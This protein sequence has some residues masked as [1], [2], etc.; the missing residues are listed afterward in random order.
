MWNFW[1]YNRQIQS[2]PVVILCLLL[3]G[4]VQTSHGQSDITLVNNGDPDNRVD[5]AIFGDGYTT[6]QMDIYK[7]R[8][9]KLIDGIFNEEPFKEYQDYFNVHR[10]D[11][12]S[13][14]SG[15]DFPESSPPVFKDTAFDS[16]YRGGLNADV[17][18]VQELASD[19]LLP[20][21][22]DLLILIVNA[23]RRSGVGIGGV[24]IVGN[25]QSM[26]DIALHEIGHTFGYL[27]DEYF[28]SSIENCHDYPE[29]QTPNLTKQTERE[30]I[31]WNHW[32]DPETPIPTLT[33]DMGIPG[34]YEGGGH[35]AEGRYRPTWNSKMR[36]HSHPFEQINSEQL[37]KRI[38][39]YVSPLDAS[40]PPATDLALPFGA[41]QLFSISTPSPLTHDLN[42]SWYMNGSPVGTGLEFIFD[43]YLSGTGANNLEVIVEDD[44]EF[45]RYDPAEI[46]S[47][48]KVWDIFVGEDQGYPVVRSLTPPSVS[49]GDQDFTLMVDGMNFTDGSV[50][51]W[52]GVD[53]VTSYLS[54]TQL[55][56]SVP[57]G[58]VTSGGTTEVT[59]FN[60]APKNLS[61][62][63]VP[64]NILD[65]SISTDPSSMTLAAG[66]TA[67]STL[68][69]SPLGGFDQNVS[70][71]CTGTSPGATC[72]V[73]PGTIMLDGANATTAIIQVETT[74]DSIV[75]PVVFSGP[76][77]PE[78][79][80]LASLTLI[81][82]ILILSIIGKSVTQKSV[83]I[84]GTVK[85]TAI[86]FVLA[87]IACGG[88]GGGGGDESKE[89]ASM[90][91]L[92][93]TATSGTL[94]HSAA[95]TLSVK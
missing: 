44:T 32:I 33:T 12:V 81:L 51:R 72:T 26:V 59:V 23:D 65:F 25:S 49:A 19:L 50:V 35:C 36:G 30:L 55:T 42:V 7:N 88:G 54:P 82:A 53:L 10:I 85:L 41:I 92:T 76:L 8:V 52:G 3:F 22:R 64:F 66:Q 16:E 29:P 93:V 86:V 58:N 87:L 56:S 80:I 2:I 68:T 9:Q 31:K 4:L 6:G 13:N 78:M 34:L 15:I 74:A 45:V 47:D 94:S 39:N 62:A 95:I 75:P 48:R 20:S 57:A 70:L 1:R 18:K 40:Y 79:K 14:E 60:P 91:T 27:S 38:Y 84:P 17:S 90:S 5:I 11:V 73:T 21:Q 71:S 24:A 67:Q 37:V 77:Y 61:S 63:G 28:Y 69:L 83:W 46:L 43:S 89:T